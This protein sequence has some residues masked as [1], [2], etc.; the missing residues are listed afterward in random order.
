[1][2]SASQ[3][4]IQR[5][6][7][8]GEEEARRLGHDHLGTGH[9]LL[10]MV[11]RDL[12]LCTELLRAE[13][14]TP[15]EA[16]S[17]EMEAREERAEGAEASP[18]PV[19][20]HATWGL[21]RQAHEHAVWLESEGL[22]A[23]HALLTIVD[24]ERGAA[25]HA[26]EQKGEDVRERIERAL[27]TSLGG[28]R[29]AAREGGAPT[30]REVVALAW[31]QAHAVGR[32]E[33]EVEDLLRANSAPG[34]TIGSRAMRA[35]GSVSEWAPTLWVDEDEDDPYRRI[36]FSEECA[37]VLAAAAE[38]ARRLGRDYVA[39]EHL[40][41]GACQAAPERLADFVGA[42]VTMERAHQVVAEAVSTA[43]EAR[44]TE[45]QRRRGGE[46]TEPEPT[47][48]DRVLAGALEATEFTGDAGVG[49]G[50][51]GCWH[52]LLAAILLNQDEE[53]GDLLQ[54]MQLV[55]AEIHALGAAAEDLPVAAGIALAAARREG[56]LEAFDFIVVFVSVGSPRVLKALDRLG[57]TADEVVAQLRNWRLE[58]EGDTAGSGSTLPAT[59]LNM[60]FGVLTTI[61]LIQAVVAEGDW[62][63]LIF[64]WLVWS[65]HPGYG[66]TGS[67]VVAGL[68]AAL[69][70]PLVGLLH[71][72]GIS[73]DL[74][75][76]RS[77]RQAVWGRTGV[78]LSL[79]ELRCVTRRRLGFGGAVNQ[80]VRQSAR[81]AIRTRVLRLSG[82]DG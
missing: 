12:G 75:Q 17:I 25:A 82:R 24:G 54:D 3:I 76:A 42:K 36:P 74:L 20:T 40:L 10:A 62:W 71:L 59:G 15:A 4:S 22:G 5:L 57:L 32:D 16:E 67:V 49:E 33:I 11:D 6:V 45:I 61:V 65:G 38:E 63:K 9:L 55:P 64:I 68:L 80:F 51:P 37:E 1:M 2:L 43:D 78:H 66:P 14:L 39:T 34:W 35:L 29:A 31:S 47:L 79:R 18:A 72:L 56:E 53:L 60:L 28:E 41:L 69:V 7:G 8:Y 13:G 23:E 27:L 77:E 81:A 26:L 21:L 44:D 30:A 50:Q 19:P 70:S 48:A 46:E 58:R 52:G 73:A